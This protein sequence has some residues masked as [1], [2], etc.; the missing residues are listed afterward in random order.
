MF[1]PFCQGKF[2]LHFANLLLFEFVGTHNHL[3]LSARCEWDPEIRIE[4]PDKVPESDFDP[5]SDRDMETG[6]LIRR[7]RN[8]PPGAEG[9]G[10]FD[11][12]DYQDEDERENSELVFTKRPFGGL[13]RDL[14]RKIKWLVN[15]Y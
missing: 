1:H 14:K 12:F 6:H 4:P 8:T 9:A 10:G 7:R 11:N 5:E 2:F 3:I 13:V 15:I